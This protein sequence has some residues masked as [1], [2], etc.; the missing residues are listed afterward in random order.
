MGIIAALPTRKLDP[1]FG[2][3]IGDCST[4]WLFFKQI[5]PEI[6]AIVEQSHH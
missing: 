4:C 5:K 1:L 2:G 6:D 3:V